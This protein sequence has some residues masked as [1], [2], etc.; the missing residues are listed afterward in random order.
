MNETNVILP[1]PELPVAPVTK[2]DR[3]RAAFYRLLPELLKTHQGKYV[4]IHEEKVFDSDADDL[5]LMMR[6]LPRVGSVEIY[7]ELVTA[8]PR[9]PIR[10]PHYR[11]IRLSGVA[12]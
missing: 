11:E 7:L 8:E 5:V 3:E 6:V 9:K 4:A 10:I 2:F 12:S 1:A